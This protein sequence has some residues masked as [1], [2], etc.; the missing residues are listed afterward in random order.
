ME[1]ELYGGGMLCD[2]YSLNLCFSCE[3]TDFDNFSPME[4]KKSLKQFE[5]QFCSRL[6]LRLTIIEFGARGE[7]FDLEGGVHQVVF[8]NLW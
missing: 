3:V 7:E 8:H 4:Q 1:E 5:I 2:G 6:T